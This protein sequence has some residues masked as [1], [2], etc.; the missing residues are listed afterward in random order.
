MSTTTFVGSRSAESGAT[1][2]FLRWRCIICG[3]IYD[4]AL[5][6]PQ[7]GI[8]PGTAWSDVAESWTCPDCGVRKSDFVMALLQD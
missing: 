3:F 8:A 1:A 4:E 5:G 7:E 6:L 2:V